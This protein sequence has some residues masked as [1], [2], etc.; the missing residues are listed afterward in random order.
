MPGK[1]KIMFLFR[2]APHGTIYAYEGL[3]SLLIFC[4]Y[5]Q[6]ITLV[7]MDD[8]V[9]ALKKGQDTTE[10]GTKEFSTTFRVLEDYGIERICVDKFSMKVR[11]LTEKDL[12]IDVETL[13]EK[14]IMAL[15]K[16]QDTI[17]PF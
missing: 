14:E 10:I 4:S 5:E 3:E 15:M 13:D 2:N 9:Y 8:A 12:L 17:L 6:E 7:L 1:T 11:G 16:E